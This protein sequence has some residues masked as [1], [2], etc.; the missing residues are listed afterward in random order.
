M[1]TYEVRTHGVWSSHFA[2]AGKHENAAYDVSAAATGPRQLR[3]GALHR[4][5][6]QHQD[7]GLVESM[8]RG[9][10]TPAVDQSRI[11]YDPSGAGLSEHGVHHF[12]GPLIEA[13]RSLVEPCPVP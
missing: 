2:A 10:R 12:H 6:M 5:P 1:D 7:L 9:M 3:V 11:V 13:D 8:Q 4:R